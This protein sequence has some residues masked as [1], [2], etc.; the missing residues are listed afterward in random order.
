MI[1]LVV[2]L[3]AL[4]ASTLTLFSGFGLGTLLLP[5]FAL[6]F[7][8]ELA[9]AA[10][11]VVHLANNVFKL[12]LM[13]RYARVATVLAFGVPAIVGAVGGAWL[14]KGLSGLPVV[15]GYTI[16]GQRFELSLLK[17][18]LGLLIV[19]FAW[20]ELRSGRESASARRLGMGWGGLLSGFFGGLS[21]HQGALRSA[22]LVGSGLDKRAFIATG[23]S[24]A[25]MV[26]VARIAVYGFAFV[27]ALVAA[28]GERPVAGLLAA[29]MAS[30]FAGAWI[31]VR[32]IGKVTL[33]GVRR[34]VGTLLV[35]VGLALASGLV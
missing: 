12:A 26:D 21:G 31:G 6:V 25:V 18:A 15:G 3:V 20:V 22:F 32:L 8:A 4:A 17:I 28:S 34:W 24:C 14:L 33:E 30:A 13:G 1:W 11:A 2:C 27:G 16:A 35:L 10:T 7:P 9:V 29:A 5:A 19:A 23:V